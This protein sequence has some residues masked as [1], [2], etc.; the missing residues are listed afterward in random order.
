MNDSRFQMIGMVNAYKTVILL[1]L[2]LQQI[3][4]MSHK[5]NWQEENLQEWVALF[6]KIQ[7]KVANK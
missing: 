2:Q 3:Q 5:V 1:Q 7:V 4:S 6:P